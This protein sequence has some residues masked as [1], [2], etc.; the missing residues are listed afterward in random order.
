MNAARVST[1]ESTAGVGSKE[2]VWGPGAKPLVGFGAKPRQL[3]PFLIPPG[4][5]KSGPNL[6]N[7][8]QDGCSCKACYAQV[9]G[10]WIDELGT[11]TA[12]GEWQIFGTIT[13]ATRN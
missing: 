9:M 11:R 12:S 4:V 7:S 5:S 8:H 1:K 10:K 13:Y 3:F 6:R 2:S